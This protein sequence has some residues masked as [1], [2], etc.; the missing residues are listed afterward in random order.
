MP[1]RLATTNDI[2]ELQAL[3]AA[4][5]RALSKGLYSTE[6]AEAA[7]T[8]VFG[9]DSQ[10]VADGTYY[11]IA[12]DDAGD[13]ALAAAGGWSARRTLYGGDQVSGRADLALDP[14][15]MPART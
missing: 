2:P 6:Q 13:T 11:L 4:S 12:N 8:H 14:A 7:L 5:V 3:I 10:L 1:L 15:T 9:V